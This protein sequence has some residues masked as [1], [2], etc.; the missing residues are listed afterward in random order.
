MKQLGLRAYR[1]S[2]VWTR[3]LPEGRGR[4]NQAGIYFY[5]RLVDD[6]LETGVVPFLTLYH[7]DLPQA[8]QDEGEWTVRTTTEAFAEYADLVS[9]HLGDWVKNW[10]THD[11][12]YCV[13]F[14]G[15]EIGSDAP[16]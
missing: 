16:G 14:L 12:P 15:H 11:E 8:L 6:P 2:I 4:I 3:F 10:I 13:A 7:W 1:F 9:R 5:S